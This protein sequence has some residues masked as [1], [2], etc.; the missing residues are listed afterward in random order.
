MIYK[1]KEAHPIVD[2]SAYVHPQATIIGSVKI[3]KDVFIGAS[4]IFF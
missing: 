1:F 4:L 3:G 2:P